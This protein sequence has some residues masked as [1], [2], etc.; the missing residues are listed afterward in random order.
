MFRNLS[1]NEINKKKHKESQKLKSMV[2]EMLNHFA[3]IIKDFRYYDRYLL[4]ESDPWTVQK[5]CKLSVMDPT[6]FKIFHDEL[7]QN[8]PVSKEF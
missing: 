3:N 2:D 4:I 7:T 6:Y 5:I 8:L 1:L